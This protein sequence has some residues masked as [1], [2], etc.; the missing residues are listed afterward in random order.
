MKTESI[1][2]RNWDDLVFENRH[3]AYGAYA[4]RKDYNNNMLKGLG[5]SVA[6]A[7]L[8][9]LIPK[10]LAEIKGVEIVPVVC[11]FGE[12]PLVML[13]DPPRVQPKPRTT[14]PPPAVHHTQT[15][16]PPQV[17]SEPVETTTA[18]VSELIDT[19]PIDFGETGTGDAVE[20]TGTGTVEIPAV[21]TAPQVWDLVQEMPTYE[22]GI[23]AMSRFLSRNIKYPASDRRIGTQGTVFVSF[24]INSEGRVTQVRVVRG[25]SPTCDAE[26]VRVVSLMPPWK[27]GIQ[28]KQAVAVRMMLPITFKINQ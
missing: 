5:I 11:T 25:I 17:T 27:P 23:A 10:L 15:N 18:T 26:A 6:L 16:L 2:I 7:C 19:A 24:I 4:V 14:P 9:I 12:K 3:R 1:S 13:S 28:N 21:S 20:T 22:G 8:L